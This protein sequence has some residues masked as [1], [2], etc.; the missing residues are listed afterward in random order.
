MRTVEATIDERGK[1]RLLEPIHVTGTRRVLV[2][3]FE[4]GEEGVTLRPYGLAYGKFTVPADFD[5]PLPDHILETF[6][7]T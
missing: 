7:G 2:T 3:I 1:V 6:E 5:D 4:E